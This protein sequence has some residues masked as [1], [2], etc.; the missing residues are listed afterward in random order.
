M[1]VPNQ[2]GKDS[3]IFPDRTGRPELQKK[4]HDHLTAVRQIGRDFAYL[5]LSAEEAR[6]FIE[7]VSPRFFPLLVGEPFRASEMLK[8]ETVKDLI[9]AYGFVKFTNLLASAAINK[10]INLEEELIRLAQKK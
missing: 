10:P 5:G 4:W 2:A 3:E 7:Q 8:V 1:L 9:K 6:S